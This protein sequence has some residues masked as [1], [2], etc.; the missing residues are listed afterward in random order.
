MRGDQHPGIQT[1]TTETIPT[2][3]PLRCAGGNK[4]DDNLYL[5][6]RQEMS[7]VAA[8]D[9]LILFLIFL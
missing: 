3:Y 8:Y 2:R 9:F 1:D 5:N 4:D 6:R 7:S